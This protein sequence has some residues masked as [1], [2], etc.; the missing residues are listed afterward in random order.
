MSKVKVYYVNGGETWT[1][2]FLKVGL[3][4][5]SIS[6][7][8]KYLHN[9][10]PHEL[11]MKKDFD[12]ELTALKQERD[13]YREAL[14]KVNKVKYGLD[15]NSSKDQEITY[16]ANLV[17]EYRNIANAALTKWKRG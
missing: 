1:D 2:E 4:S 10:K 14:E 12:R 15:I 11:V 3:T 6:T 17:F 13:E 5:S 16:W 9:K 8:K 7:D